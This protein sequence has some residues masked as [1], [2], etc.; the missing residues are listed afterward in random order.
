MPDH[1]EL[2]AGPNIRLDQRQIGC[3]ILIV[4]GHP[5]EHAILAQ[6]GPVQIAVPDRLV[7]RRVPIRGPGGE[8]IPEGPSGG[9]VQRQ[10]GVHRGR[11]R[12]GTP[13]HAID[14]QHALRER[15]HHDVEGNARLGDV[16]RLILRLDV[17][18]IAARPQIC[19][20]G[21]GQIETKIGGHAFEGIRIPLDIAVVEIHVGV[22]LQ[23]EIR[24]RPFR[25][26]ERGSVRRSFGHLQFRR[27]SFLNEKTHGRG[28]GI[29]HPQIIL[30]LDG[31]RMRSHSQVRE[32]AGRHIATHRGP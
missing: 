12:V 5:D 22:P 17:H 2:P 30:G 24:G 21:L 19:E 6:L 32:G 9:A 23:R 25:H 29:D 10:T 13:I 4:R 1:Q 31:E 3:E 27:K 8:P 20:R 14:R 28:R 18:R 11:F 7:S 26:K 15:R 16:A